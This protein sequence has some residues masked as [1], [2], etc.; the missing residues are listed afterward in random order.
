M[1]YFDIAIFSKDGAIIERFRSHDDLSSWKEGA[2]QIELSAAVSLNADAQEGTLLKIFG[3]PRKYLQQQYNLNECRIEVFAG[4]GKGFP[5][6]KPQQRGMLLKG[7][8]LETS[9]ILEQGNVILTLYITAN[10][11]NTRKN[12]TDIF[13]KIRKGEQFDNAIKNAL[14]GNITVNISS[15]LVADYNID[16]Y[17]KTF[18]DF[19]SYLKAVSKHTIKDS[20]YNGIDA[21]HRGG[22]IIITDFSSASGKTIKIDYSDLIGQPTFRSIGEIDARVVLR[23]DIGIGDLVEFPDRMNVQFGQGFQLNARQQ[24]TFKG[25]WQVTELH[26]IGSSRG[27]AGDSWVTVIKAITYKQGGATP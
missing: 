15:R 27:D 25:T 23:A 3:V 6:A 8:I 24:T 26:H 4:M 18:E 17:F 5:L 14:S 2:L 10:V 1:R 7:T 12:P 20:N 21:T 13:F 19:I 9:P 11:I 16:K 22:G